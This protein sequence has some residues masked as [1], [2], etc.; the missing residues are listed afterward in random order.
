MRAARRAAHMTIDSGW[1]KI[2]KRGAPA[3][4]AAKLAA[5]PGTVFIDGQIKLMKGDHVKTWK[6]YV[7]MQFFHTIDRCFQT[8]AHTVVLGFDNYAHVPTA[9]NMTQRKRSQHVP[10]VEFA[11]TDELPSVLPPY[12]DAAMRNRSFKAKV[13]T[14]VCNNVRRKY[15]EHPRTVVIDFRGEVE[16]LGAPRALPPLLTASPPARRGECDIKAFAYAQADAPL[17]ICSTDGDFVPLSLLQIERALEAGLPAPRIFLYRIRVHVDEVGEKR[18]AGREY[19]YVDVNALYE[20]VRADLGVARPA[21]VLGAMIAST[22]CDF[23]M[24]LPQLGPARLWTHRHAL[25]GAL[26]SVEGE[27]SA[28]DVLAFLVRAYTEL[29]TLRVC[30][31][32]APT[33][34][35]D[36]RDRAVS[37]LVAVRQSA[38]VAE[39]VRQS[40]WTPS[41]LI[42][43]AKNA[44]WT[45]QYWTLLHEHPDPITGDYGY[46]S[47]AG[48]VQFRT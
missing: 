20:Y 44:A 45:V 32:R 6:Q 1:V 24:N 46:D 35:L 38:N 23:C 48:V 31:D 42:A 27:L 19:E 2:L 15:A 17:L 10:P 5:V 30:I 13:M 3:A 43:H 16:V 41:R 7:E 9:K 11:S 4:F 40:M 18:K 47:Q 21:L 29:F 25:K 37:V 33:L 12:W 36:A 34:A 8:G 28:D 39:R 14:L 22:G 26:S